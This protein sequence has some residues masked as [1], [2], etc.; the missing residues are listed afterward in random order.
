MS[1]IALVALYDYLTTNDISTNIYY[2]IHRKL[3]IRKMLKYLKNWR[4]KLAKLQNSTIHYLFQ[5]N[6]TNTRQWYVKCP[7]RTTEIARKPHGHHNGREP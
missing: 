7:S 5:P 4:S 1:Y 3:K 6:T 2:S